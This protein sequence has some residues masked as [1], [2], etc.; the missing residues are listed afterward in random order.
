[1]TQAD[2]KAVME[3]VFRECDA[4][5]G[6]GQ[7]EYAGGADAF[8]NFNRLAQMLG[9]DRKAVLL[10][11]AVKH[12]DG[13]AS[14]V[15]GHRSQREHVFGRINDLIVYLILLRGMIQEDE[16]EDIPDDA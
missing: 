4:L 10:V 11:Y 7:L 14:Y 1:V 6:A 5:R 8:G 16:H 12:W 9:L 3:Q 15:R 2:M 13:I